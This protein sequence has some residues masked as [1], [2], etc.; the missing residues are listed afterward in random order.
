MFQNCPDG[1]RMFWRFLE[2]LRTFK[3]F[4]NIG[5]RMPSQEVLYKANNIP[6]S[7]MSDQG[8]DRSH[9]QSIISKKNRR[10]S[11]GVYEERLRLSE[12]RS[13]HVQA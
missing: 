13:T 11:K 6:H 3:R 12:A 7:H 8:T 10:F 4:E 9:R 5:F 2:Y 1:S